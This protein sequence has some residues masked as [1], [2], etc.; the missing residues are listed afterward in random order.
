ML[1]WGR[2]SRERWAPPRSTAR[3]DGWYGLHNEATERFWMDDPWRE[4]VPIALDST[5]VMKQWIGSTHDNRSLLTW[6]K[7][8]RTLRRRQETEHGLRKRTPWHRTRCFPWSSINAFGPASRHGSEAP[9]SERDQSFSH[10]GPIQ[11]FSRGLHDVWLEQ[12]WRKEINK[13]RIQKPKRI[14]WIIIE[15]VSSTL[16]VIEPY[17]HTKVIK[18]LGHFSVIISASKRKHDI[19]IPLMVWWIPL[20]STLLNLENSEHSRGSF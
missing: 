9:T 12:W 15:F 7:E 18:E 10:H 19:K 11:S 16:I 14:Q 20:T 4:V 6:P 13:R 8:Q 2:S 17:D 3:C 1:Q 5:C